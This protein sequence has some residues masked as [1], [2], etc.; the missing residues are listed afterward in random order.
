MMPLVL[1]ATLG[2]ALAA[3]TVLAALWL[4]GSGTRRVEN[5]FRLPEPGTNSSLAGEELDI[6]ALLAVVQPSVVTLD[7]GGAAGLGVFEGA[8]TGLLIDDRGLILTNAHVVL[9][10]D[11]IG[12][13]FF[14]GSTTTAEIVGSF[15]D[16]DIAVIQ[17]AGVSGLV[18][19]T[20]GS[21]EDLRVGDD[22]VAIG[23]A[24]G[25]GGVPSV[26][27][28][29]VS[30][31][32]R[33]IAAEN[34]SLENLIQTDAAINPGNSGGP[35]V[36]AAGE[37]VGINTAIL[38]DAQN[39]GF[40]IAIDVVKPLIERVREGDADLRPETAFLGVSTISLPV[41]DDAVRSQ[42]G[43]TADEGAFVQDVVAA[44]PAES[45]GILR[46][47]V[48]VAL[49]GAAVATATDVARAVRERSPGDT[50]T[51]E[52]RRGDEVVTV[53]VSLTVR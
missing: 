13:T 37:V 5:V 24:L 28:G 19:A 51:L 30:A 40:A 7:V 1:A 20:L 10:A 45:A 26:T 46:G 32:D 33:S 9:D 48:I 11:E 49:D 27:R 50:V 29:I 16:D 43:V 6:Q 2:A 31:K 53:E 25:L 41:L 36:N 22:V 42:F 12:V 14:D 21:S 4:F 23:N 15:P 3:A 38:D 47:D 44:S 18:P 39:V 17:A 8:G 52:I 35:L 34:V